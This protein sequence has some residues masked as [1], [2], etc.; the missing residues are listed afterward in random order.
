MLQ[1]VVKRDLLERIVYSAFLCF[2]N[3]SRCKLHSLRSFGTLALTILVVM[4]L[5]PRWHDVVRWASA[6]AGEVF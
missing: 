3:S 5:C 2:A 4:C 1:V 6:A